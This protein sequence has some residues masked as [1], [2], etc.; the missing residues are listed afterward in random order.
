MMVVGDRIYSGSGQ[1]EDPRC[2][3]QGCSLAPGPVRASSALPL[4]PLHRQAMS[5]VR[6]DLGFQMWDT[7]CSC[8]VNLDSQAHGYPYGAVSNK[9]LFF[10]YNPSYSFV[11]QNCSPLL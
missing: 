9:T 8:P 2:P 7:A 5:R 6:M 3:P 4:P 10:F 11:L 1:R